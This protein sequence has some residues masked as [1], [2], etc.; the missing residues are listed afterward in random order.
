M[1]R[2]LPRFLY[3]SFYL[4]FATSQAHAVEITDAWMRALPPGQPT[5]A[6]YLTLNNPGDTPVRVVAVSAEFAERAEIHESRQ[7]DGMWRMRRLEALEV[8]AGGQ[9]ALE[10]GGAHLMLF[11]L[12]Q[13]VR[14][15]D[16]LNATLELENGDTLAVTITVESPGGAPHHNH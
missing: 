11:G 8:P 9:V 10:P 14:P 1:F 6:A 7:V 12:R 4:V 5:A 3:L 16:N 2:F 13:A 15:G